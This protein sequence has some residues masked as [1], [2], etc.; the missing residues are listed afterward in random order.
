[1]KTIFFLNK[2]HLL[3]NYDNKLCMIC[4]DCPKFCVDLILNCHKHNAC[5]CLDCYNELIK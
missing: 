4:F 5:I 3:K 1:M 2:M